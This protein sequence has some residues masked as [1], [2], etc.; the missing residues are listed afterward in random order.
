MRRPIHA[1]LL[2]YCRRAGIEFHYYACHTRRSSR[3]RTRDWSQIR[4]VALE[5]LLG[6]SAVDLNW[7]GIR[8]KIESGV[9]LVTGAAGSIGSE[10]CRQIARFQPAALVGFDCSETALFEI[11]QEMRRLYPTLAFYPEIGSIQNR[12]RLGDVFRRYRP[13]DRLSRGGLQARPHD[14]IACVRS[15]RE[16]HL[17]NL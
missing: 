11:E 16:Q 7:T 15:D 5:D 8:R 1:H 3:G 10:L 13:S 9:V 6:R 12:H 2:K 14:G 17:R 4:D